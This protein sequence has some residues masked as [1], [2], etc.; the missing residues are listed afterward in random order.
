MAHKFLGEGCLILSPND[1]IK[2]H[3]GD[4][5]NKP[6]VSAIVEIEERD[7]TLIVHEEIPCMSILVDQ[8]V[9]ISRFGKIIQVGLKVPIF[10]Q[11]Q[12]LRIR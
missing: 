2:Q 1:D 12:R 7:S 6:A 11:Y 8:A 5:I 10:T 3:D 4:I 9:R